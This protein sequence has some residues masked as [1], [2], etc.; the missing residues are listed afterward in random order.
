MKLWMQKYNIHSSS[1][2]EKLWGHNEQTN[3]H[4]RSE[5]CR[6]WWDF[7]STLKKNMLTA[8]NPAAGLCEGTSS[9]L[10]SVWP[11]LTIHRGG[12]K[13]CSRY[14]HV[15]FFCEWVLLAN[16]GGRKHQ[17]HWSRTALPQRVQL[18]NLKPAEWERRQETGLGFTLGLG[19]F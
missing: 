16:S 8:V 9:K 17:Q 12:P 2:V 14:I 6:C 7:R 18:K 10:S 11:L 15:Q 5:C 1:V 13:W 4:C 19:L 3:K